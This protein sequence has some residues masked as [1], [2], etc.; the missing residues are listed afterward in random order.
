LAVTGPRSVIQL[1]RVWNRGFSGA[2]AR[3]V[4]I[5]LDPDG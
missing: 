1:D 5:L 2:K 4:I 3:A